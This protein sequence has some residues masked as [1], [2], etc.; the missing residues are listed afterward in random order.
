M[1]PRMNRL[2]AAIALT[3]V[4]FACTRALGD[5]SASQSRG[6]KRQ[7]TASLVACMRKRMSY[8]RSA[9]YNEAKKTCRD[10]IA[11]QSGKASS[12]SLVA[13]ATPPKP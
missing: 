12:G 1:G 6:V 9:S 13:S 11:N 2:A 5:E 8:D 3:G 7:A 4:V 10:Q